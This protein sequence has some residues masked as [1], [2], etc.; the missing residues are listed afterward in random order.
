MGRRMVEN[1]DILIIGAGMAGASAAYE[2]A[3]ER[4]VILLE[5]ESQPGYHTTGRSAALFTEAYGNLPIRR[6]TSASRAFFKAPPDCFGD[7][8]LLTPRGT[9]FIASAEQIPSLEKA[10][11]D[12]PRSANPVTRVS[13]DEAIRLNPALSPD[14]VAGALHEPASE[15]ID[16]H[17]VHGGFLRGLRQRG[18][19]VATDAEVKALSRDG[20]VWVAETPSGRFAAPVVVNAAGAWCDHVAGLAGIAPC[21]LMP[22]RRTAFLFDPPDGI[23]MAAAPA[24]IDIDETFYFKPDA[25][26]VLGSPADETPSPP[27]DAQPEEIDV[28][29]GVYLIE[30]ATGMTIRR[31][32]HK[33]AGLRSFVADKTPVIGFDPDHDGFF[34]LAGQGGYGIQTAPAIARAVAGLIGTGALPDDLVAAGLDKAML[35]VERL[36]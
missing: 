14:Y 9:L 31:I 6:L 23:D 20:G 18:G 24:T 29:T 26:R 12:H 22:K 17:A 13:T 7:D 27:C 8:P 34:W 33:W 4:R 16:V 21:G 28:A 11:A 30:Q 32:T 10:L 36:R 19:V 15:D 25:G 2:L 5:Q 35:G 1:A 3:A